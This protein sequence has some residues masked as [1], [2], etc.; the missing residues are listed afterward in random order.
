M[1]RIHSIGD[2]AR[3]SELSIKAIR[4]YEAIGLIPRPTRRTNGGSNGGHRVFTAAEIDRLKFIRR[5]RMLDLGL[6]DV[7]RLLAIR[8]AGSCPGKEP[9]YADILDRHLGEIEGRIAHLRELAGQIREIRT[10]A[11][12]YG[13]CTDEGCGCLRTRSREPAGV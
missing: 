3:A 12:H 11:P 5:A 13:G 7:R 9:A 2:A 4:H 6:D 8:D 1:D 10:G